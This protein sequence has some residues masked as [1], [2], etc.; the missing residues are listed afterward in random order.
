MKNEELKAMIITLMTCMTVMSGFVLSIVYFD[1]W[2]E[3]SCVK[4]LI[5]MVVSIISASGAF[6]I[7]TLELLHRKEDVKKEEEP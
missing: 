6:S 4:N 1:R 3:M 5:W 2:A 7:F